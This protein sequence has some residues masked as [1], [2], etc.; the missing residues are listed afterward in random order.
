M[1]REAEAKLR[2]EESAERQEPQQK[3]QWPCEYCNKTF[4]MYW[5]LQQHVDAVHFLERE[6]A[7]R[8]ATQSTNAPIVLERMHIF[9]LPPQMRNTLECEEAEEVD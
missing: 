9:A 5:S 2:A 4:A 1:L 7:K 8:R 6:N 3:E